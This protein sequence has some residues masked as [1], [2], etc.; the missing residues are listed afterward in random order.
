MDNNFEDEGHA[1]ATGLLIG[2]LSKAI[3]VKPTLDGE[4]DYTPVLAVEI[5][6]VDDGDSGPF[7]TVFIRVLAD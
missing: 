6:L 3:T 2:H 7:L 5:P 4:G 1:L